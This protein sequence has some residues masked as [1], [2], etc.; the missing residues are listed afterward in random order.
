MIRGSF[1]LWYGVVVA[2]AAAGLAFFATLE[3]ARS[4]TML[5]LTLAT[6][7]SGTHY[8]ALAHPGYRFYERR[9]VTL[10]YWVS[11]LALALGGALFTEQFL[12]GWFTV[13]GLA[14]TGAGVAVLVYCQ[15]LLARPDAAPP[16][17]ARI[18]TSLSVYL[19]AFLL[20]VA[21]QSLEL[22]PAFHMG[23][24]GAVSGVLSLAI[25]GERSTRLDRPVLYAG[26]ISLLIIE[27]S[28]ALLLL[29]VGKV[30]TGLLLLM[31]FYL[32]SGLAQSHLLNRL[33]RS[34][35]LEFVG[36]TLVAMGVLYWFQ[37][38]AAG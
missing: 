25:L 34:V 7:A 1:L 29:P 27:L 6:I 20:F 38:A 13:A 32:F 19:A 5:V 31:A 12:G 2:L 26:V 22:P 28:W 14:G 24:L 18:A 11:P 33:N 16:A 9:P 8:L 10:P 21:L 36:V 23:V 37:A 35:A 30:I 15:H 3:G 17:F 4:W